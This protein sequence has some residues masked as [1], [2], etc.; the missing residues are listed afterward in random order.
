M[1][2]GYSA[3]GKGTAAFLEGGGLFQ[4]GPPLHYR[5]K[6][7]GRKMGILSESNGFTNKCLV[8]R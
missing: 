2:L 1:E 7:L 6:W 3:P 5:G 8:L 4:C